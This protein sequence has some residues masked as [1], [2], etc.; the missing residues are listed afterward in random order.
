M[1]TLSGEDFNR[2][3]KYP[4]VG[5]DW[6]VHICLQ[7]ALLLFLCIFLIGIPFLTGFII[8]ITRQGIDGSNIYP[9]WGDWGLYWKRGWKALA[10][11]LIYYLPLAAMFFIYVSL[12]VIPLLLGAITET[13]VLA[14]IGSLI[15]ALGV[16]VLYFFMFIYVFCFA[17][18]Q[19]VT[20]PLLALD[21]PISASFQF[22]RYIWPY[23]KANAVSLL[24]AWLIGYLAGLLANV[25]LLFLFFGVVFTIP[26]AMAIMAYANGTIYRISEVK[27]HG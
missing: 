24:L 27:Y 25:G 1:N 19:M 6:F 4:F 7:G 15:G 11:N 13:E 3:I 22:S 16:F 21:Y 2:I 12:V 23:I 10:V 8:S 18:I 17:V 14:A 26:L 9:S 20:A 5:K